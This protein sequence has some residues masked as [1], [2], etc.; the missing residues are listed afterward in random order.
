MQVIEWLPTNVSR[1]VVHVT[2]P[3]SLEVVEHLGVLKNVVNLIE[4]YKRVSGNVLDV[5]Q[6][7]RLLK[8][9]NELCK[10]SRDLSYGLGA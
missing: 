8:C 4:S 3:T 9:M 7:T 1:H 5:N 2:L 6:N 10:I